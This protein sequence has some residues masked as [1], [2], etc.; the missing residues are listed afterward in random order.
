[1]WSGGDSRLCSSMAVG[2]SGSLCVIV[3]FVIVACVAAWL[4]GVDME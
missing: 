2:D 1:M 3:G 4:L